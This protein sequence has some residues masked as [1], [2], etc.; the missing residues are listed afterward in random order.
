[1]KKYSYIIS[2]LAL[3]SV[4]VS[5]FSDE[6]T[7]ATSQKATLQ[8]NYIDEVVWVVGDEAILRSDIELMRMQGEQENINWGGDPKCRI[9]EQIA[10]Q[11][12]FVNQAATDSRIDWH[13]GLNLELAFAE[14]CEEKKASE[15]VVKVVEKE[16]IKTVPAQAQGA[17]AAEAPVD[18]DLEENIAYVQSRIF[19]RKGQTPDPTVTMKDIAANWG[20]A[21]KLIRENDAVLEATMARADL[22][23]VKNGVLYLGF[24]RETIKK[25]VEENHRFLVWTSAAISKVLGKSVGICCTIQEPSARRS[26]NNEVQQSEALAAALSMGGKVVVDKK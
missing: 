1:M 7:D 15:Q 3:L 5:S 12:L 24:P 8:P 14:S 9:P 2:T 6:Q 13:P 16:V 26:F 19:I 4:A 21:R 10:V 25:K 20:A 18:K 17:A 22:L 23:E 11:K